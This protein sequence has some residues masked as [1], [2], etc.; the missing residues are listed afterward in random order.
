MKPKKDGG[1]YPES[2]YDPDGGALEPDTG[3]EY[4]PCQGYDPILDWSFDPTDV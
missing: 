3:G 4:K 2:G 1:Y